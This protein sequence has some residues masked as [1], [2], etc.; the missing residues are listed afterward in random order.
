VDK[1]WLIKDWYK[2]LA[3][4][5]EPD[6]SFHKC[7]AC[8][9]CGKEFGHNVVIEPPA[10]PHYQPV[11][12]E[13]KRVQRLRLKFGKLGT[14]ALISHL[15][16]IRLLERAVRRAG[17]P[18]AYSAGF[19][20]LPKIS[21]AKALP[22]GQTSAGELAD[23]EL[24]AV[25]E[26]AEFQVKLQAQLPAEIPL[27]EVIE[28]PLHDPSAEKLIA[29]A[30]YRLIINHQGKI[31]LAEMQ[32]AIRAILQAENIPYTQIS[33]SGKEQSVNLRDR[34][35]ALSLTD[36]TPTQ[37]QIDYTGI[38]TIEQNLKPA[39]VL[40]LLAQFTHSDLTLWQIHRCALLFAETPSPCLTTTK[41]GV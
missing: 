29:Q 34:L 4:E 30:S 14:M 32:S 8:G 10:I 2:A 38:C 9:V 23:M 21:I 13:K 22:L 16:L 31:T 5:V 7:Y 37:M 33:K 20:P 39:H 1:R 3:Q 17:L 28:V 6:C 18:I 12:Q 24:T 11:K 41:L 19:H 35:Y 27:Y 36:Y 15:D 25:M 26:P 40:W